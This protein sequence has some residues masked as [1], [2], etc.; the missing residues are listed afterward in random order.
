MVPRQLT[1][2]H[3]GNA[4]ISYDLFAS[5]DGTNDPVTVAD[6]LSTELPTLT[7]TD[8]RYTM[9]N[10]Q[11]SGT[12]VTGKRNITLDFGPTTNS[13]GADS[14]PFDSVTTLTSLLQQLRVSGVDPLWFTTVS[15][16]QGTTTAHADSYFEL[17]KRNTPNA[18]AEHIRVNYAGL[19]NWDNIVSGDPDTPAQTA[20]NVDLHVNTADQADPV[21]LTSNNTISPIP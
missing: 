13:E 16:L 4:Q 17:R 19:V 3:R 1:V 11:L 14:E 21:I 8:V 12:D 6:A 5:Y 7:N 2:E 20:F 18:T 9:H 10:M 15:T